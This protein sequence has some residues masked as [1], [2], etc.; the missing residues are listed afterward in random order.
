M[1]RQNYLNGFARRPEDTFKVDGSY[2]FNSG[3]STSHELK[4]GGRVRQTSGFSDFSWPGR[5]IVNIAGENFGNAPGASD[6]FF[7]YRR[8]VEQDIDA[9]YTSL[10]AQDTI[11]TGNWTIN[12]GFRWDLQDGEIQPGTTGPSAAPEVF[13]DGGRRVTHRSGLRL[14]RPSRRVSV[15][16][17]ALGEERDTL[18]RASFSQFP[19]ALGIG[20]IS[21]LNPASPYNYGAY[22]YFAF[23]DSNDNNLYEDGESYSFLFG[24][25]YDLANNSTNGNTVASGYD[26]QMV[27][28]LV[29]GVEHSVLPEF[30]V[31]LN[32]TYRLTEDIAEQRARLRP[33]GSTGQFGFIGSASNYV[34]GRDHQQHPSRWRGGLHGAVRRQPSARDHRFLAPDQR[35][36]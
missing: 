10:W 25:G 7:L 13:P 12:V 17:Y 2:F 36:A 30:V 8:G 21:W 31:G 1:W 4:F 33:A 20:T 29:L 27:S 32:Y 11:A 34:A 23:T 24:T 19:Q 26:P 28:E 5:N 16:T 18:L 15:R 22:A 14:E 35:F 9:D 3:S 6:F